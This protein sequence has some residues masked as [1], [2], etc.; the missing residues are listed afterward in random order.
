MKAKRLKLR[1]E[2]LAQEEGVSGG[3]EESE[4]RLTGRRRARKRCV[5]VGFTRI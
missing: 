5:E 2:N 4:L 1:G 3:G